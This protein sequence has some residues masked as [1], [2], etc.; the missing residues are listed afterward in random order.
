MRKGIRAHG[1]SADDEDGIL[2][3]MRDVDG[4][5]WNLQRIQPDGTKRFLQGGRVEEC[6]HLIGEPIVERLC[7][8]EGLATAAT[9]HEVTGSP[10]AIAFDAGNLPKVARVLHNRH[11]SV[12][13]LIC[14]DDDWKT[15]KSDGT[16]HNTGRIKA[17]EAAQAVSGVL[18][19]PEFGPDR[20]DKQTDFNDMAAALGNEAVKVLFDRQAKP[21]NPAWRN[22]MIAASDLRTMVFEPLKFIVPE[23][24]PEGLTI[25]AGRPKIGKSWLVLL[26]CIAVAAGKVALGRTGAGTCTQGDVLYLALEDGKRRLQRRMTKL[27]GA[28]GSWP[29]RLLLQTKWKR[30]DQ[31]GLED[32]RAWCASCE[33]PRLIV[34]DTL[35][36]VRAPGTSK[37]TPYQNDHDALSG[38]QQLA[39]ELGIGVIVNHHDRKMDA[40]DVFDT[41]S[42]TLGLTGAVD[43]IL[44]LTKKAQGITLHIRGRDIEDEGSLAMAWDKATCQWSVLGG[45]SEIHRSVERK[46]IVDALT[47][48][49]ETL[50][51]KDIMAAT[52]RVDRNAVD[53]LLFKMV[54][55]GEIVRAKRGRYSLPSVEAGKKERLDLT[56]DATE[57]NADLSFLPAFLES[58]ER[59]PTEGG[60]LDCGPVSGLDIGCERCGALGLVFKIKPKNAPP[61]A[62][63]QSLHRRCADQ[64]FGAQP[65]RG[66]R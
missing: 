59:P 10:V 41:V 11:P 35:A 44:V 6:F 40:D 7:I 1:L 29:S 21:Q 23:L 60:W 36:K 16:P 64:L 14:G 2:V 20:E 47:Q 5:L 34:V 46:A 39:E 24:I 37:A 57:E 66:G 22:G 9:I 8:A 15:T 32:I 27:L 3:P 43:T 18:V 58:K 38:L 45:A 63:P 31:G 55:A 62:H 42:G 33:A 12:K 19:M 65:E 49:G 25:L 4:V 56:T 54:Q 28:F 30:F 17:M 13:L 51:P 61:G 50:T 26:L 53:Q 48:A 52:G